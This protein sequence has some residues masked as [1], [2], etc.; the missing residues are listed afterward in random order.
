MSAECYWCEVNKPTIANPIGTIN[1]PLGCCK[2]CQ[3][4]ACGHHAQRDNYAKEYMC[5]NCD[6]SILIA[7]GNSDT[8]NTELDTIAKTAVEKALGKKK[9]GLDFSVLKDAELFSS[10]EDF[11]RRR[12]GYENWFPEIEAFVDNFN[13]FNGELIF[14][15]YLSTDAQLFFAAAA[16][17]LSRTT[18]GDLPGDTYP[19][20]IIELRNAIKTS[21]GLQWGAI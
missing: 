7:S 6:T 9:Y 11:K 16:F 12:K 21:G 10:F 13:S 5:F 17:V 14:F 1:T 3:V 2:N 4:L 19:E 8:V 20:Y 15:K 18:L